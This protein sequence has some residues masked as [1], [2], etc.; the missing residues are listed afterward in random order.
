MFRKA[1]LHAGY[2]RRCQTKAEHNSQL[3]LGAL[4][5]LP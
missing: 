1:S 5:Q 3:L 2:L 4:L